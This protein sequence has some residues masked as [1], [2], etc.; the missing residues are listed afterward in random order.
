MD[1]PQLFWKAELKDGS[2]FIENV[3]SFSKVESHLSDLA[4]FY[5][6][7]N[8]ET[9]FLIDFEKIIVKYKDKI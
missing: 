9:V 1:I 8:R 6:F 2:I 7:N 5:L 4:F 3:D